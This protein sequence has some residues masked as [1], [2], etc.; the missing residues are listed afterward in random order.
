MSENQNLII[1]LYN[2]LFRYLADQRLFKSDVDER[3]I[4][5]LIIATLGI[6]ILMWSHAI[7]IHIT[8]DNLTVSILGYFF[9][10]I[11]L[12]SLLLLRKNY[13]TYF[14]SNVMLS[15]GFLMTTAVAFI[16]GGFLSSNLVWYAAGPTIAAMCSGK[17]GIVTWVYITFIGSMIFLLIHALGFQFPVELSEKG[18]FIKHALLV[19]GW[20]IMGSVFSLYF[21]I[22]RENHERILKEQTQKID[23]LFRVLFHDLANSIGRVGIG[24][25]LGK[26]DNEVQ[27]KR[28]LEIASQASESMLEITQNVRKIY[29]ATKGKADLD[30]N[31]C[32]LNE[33]VDYIERIM[34]QDLEKKSIK[35]VYD[36]KAH[37][38]LKLLVDN[39]SFKNQVL[40]NI[41]SNAIKFSPIG[42]KIF[43]E[44][45]PLDSHQFILEIRDQGIGMSQH[46][47]EGLFDLGKKTSRLGTAGEQGTGFGMHIMKSFME[48]YQGRVIVDSTE[49]ENSGTTFKLVLKGEWPR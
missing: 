23:D 9:S 8:T 10:L 34:H 1:A 20:L 46:L 22:L 3:S 11:Q 35:I 43:I 48:I 29:A 17:R 19:F 6:S 18:L 28:G 38:G 2:K 32:S 24:I 14:I 13:S 40:A 31:L 37:E 33:A 21:L 47:I 39:V 49:G 42:G 30:L 36:K 16:S 27:A 5:A 26:R 4:H 12:F 41:I 25:T 7:L 15:A 44:V 45:C